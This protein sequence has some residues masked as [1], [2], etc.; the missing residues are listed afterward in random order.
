MKAGYKYT[1]DVDLKS[2]FDTIPHDRLV[3]E[4]RKYVADNHMI[5]LVEQFLKAEI[6][7]GLEH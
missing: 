6:L 3:R 2:Y 7:D 5:S 4:L 1:V